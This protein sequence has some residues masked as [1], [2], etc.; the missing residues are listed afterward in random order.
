MYM[1]FDDGAHW[2]RFQE[3]LPIV[4]VTDLRVHADD[5]VVSTQGRASGSWTT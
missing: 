2:Q 4:P 5:L 3:N 1:S